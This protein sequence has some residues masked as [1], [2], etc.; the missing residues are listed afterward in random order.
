MLEVDWDESKNRRNRRKHGIWFEEVLS[1]FDDPLAR[2][3]LDDAHSGD[4]ERFLVIGVNAAE[5]VLVVAHCY[6][7]ANS[8]I[9]LISA[10]K[11]TVKERR[12]YEKGI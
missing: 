12:I 8:V 1:V 3:F 2:V 10:R 9:R 4:E 11:A 5:K 6:R 7:E